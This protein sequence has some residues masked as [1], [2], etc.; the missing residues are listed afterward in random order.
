MK[1][2][3]LND[4]LWY[5]DLDFSECR[6]YWDLHEYIREKLRLPQWY[7]KNLPAL[8]DSIVGM[9]YLPAD[10][11]IHYHPKPGI[12]SELREE[13]IKE[14][15]EV[16]VYCEQIYDVIIVHLDV[17]EWGEELQRNLWEKELQYF[18]L[19]F[20]ECSTKVEVNEYIRQKLKLMPMD[21]ISSNFLE[22]SLV[23]LMH[24]PADITIHY[25]P[26]E[27]M[28]FMLREYMQEIFQA[29]QKVAQE[30]RVIIVHLDVEI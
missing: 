10:V 8:E 13:D 14:I 5:V 25:H 2:Y 21:K 4:E 22:Y 20:S 6:T 23:D 12:K 26:K 16:F 17:G 19:D 9:M 3:L 11:T 1:K 29:F 28:D 15:V 27:K 30:N 24:V 7:G 18:D